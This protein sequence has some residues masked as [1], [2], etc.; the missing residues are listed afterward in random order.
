MLSTTEQKRSYEMPNWTSN[1]I[2]RVASR[3]EAGDRSGGTCNQHAP[4]LTLRKLMSPTIIDKYVDNRWGFLQVHINLQTPTS[5][6]MEA[7]M[8]SNSPRN[9][10][11]LFLS[12][13]LGMAVICAAPLVVAYSVPGRALQDTA[14]AGFNHAVAGLLK[15]GADVHADHDA[16]LRWAA[17]SGKMETVALLLDRGA[18]V[19]AAYDFALRWAAANGHTETVRVLLDHGADIHA[20]N[21]EA[22]QNAAYSNH[23]E[24]VRLLEERGARFPEMYRSRGV[25]FPSGPQQ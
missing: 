20:K 17:A 14:T 24:T 22:L 10:R 8:S 18:D 5:Q 2:R 19:H 3:D 11:S 12:T 6:P 4:S 23:I 13:A 16:A 25:A 21:D 1:T 9:I 15:L 7:A